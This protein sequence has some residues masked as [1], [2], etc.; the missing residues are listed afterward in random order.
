[1]SLCEGALMD[2]GYYAACTA[3]VSRTQALDTIA[4]NLANVSTVGFRAEHNIF[5]SVLAST[6]GSSSSSLNAAINNYGLLSGT[7]LDKNQGALQKTGNDLDMGIE[8]PGYF[9]VQTANGPMYTRNGAFQVS[10]KGQLVT[11]TGDAVMGDKGVISMAPG[12]VSVSPDGTISSNGAVAGKL[13][14]VEFPAG[15][16]LSSVGE[17]YYSAPP[18][19]ATAA[20]SSSVR[21]GMLESSNVNPIASMVELVNAQ[22]SAEMMQRALTMFNSEIDKTATQDLPK[23]S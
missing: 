14:V 2:S 1:M 11:Q 20:T 5:S 6:G 3:L 9:V 12:A 19:T 8:G 13:K 18:N 16:Q 22:R 4:N 10:S 23:V 7:S 15:T 21:Q 17:N